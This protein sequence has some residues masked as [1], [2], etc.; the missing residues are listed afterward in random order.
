MAEEPSKSERRGRCNNCTELTETWVQLTPCMHVLCC[1]CIT[2]AHADRGCAQL[3]CP[4]L[5]EEK[6]VLC[7]RTVL[8]TT[9]HRLT[10][11]QSRLISDPPKSILPP[12]E[13]QDPIRWFHQQPK[14]YRLEHCAISMAY[15]HP[16]DGGTT[17]T[18]NHTPVDASNLSEQNKT[19]FVA[20][21]AK[22][23]GILMNMSEK[24]KEVV[25]PNS[26]MSP[27][28]LVNQA[29]TENSLLN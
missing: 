22:L 4:V 25:A 26:V 16:R 11:N 9:N 15:N 1:A 5:L 20:F 23:H 19:N 21:G 18:S 8:A 24:N 28:A 7:E 13:K 10:K 14:K 12:D 17:I 29:H 2:N 27:E 3:R 6:H